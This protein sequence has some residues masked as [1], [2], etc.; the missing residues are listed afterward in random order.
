MPGE[1]HAVATRLGER[2]WIGQFLGL[3]VDLDGAGYPTAGRPTTKISDGRDARL[4]RLLG[5]ERPLDGARAAMR[6]RVEEG[7][8]LL[9]LEGLER[10][11]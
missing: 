7:E 4:L 5:A 2:T 3:L 1:A 11:V 6:G 9:E 8:H 10:G